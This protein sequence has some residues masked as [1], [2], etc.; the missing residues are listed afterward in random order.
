MTVKGGFGSTINLKRS[1]NGL[2]G[3][4]NLKIAKKK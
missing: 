2:L 1:M 4:K 3:F